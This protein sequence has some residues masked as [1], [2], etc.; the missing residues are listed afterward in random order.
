MKKFK[1]K[2]VCTFL[3]FSQEHAVIFWLLS[4]SYKQI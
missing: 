3:L 2:T 4:F 1:V